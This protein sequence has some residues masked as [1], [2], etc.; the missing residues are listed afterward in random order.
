MFFDD[1]QEAVIPP[2]IINYFMKLH[3]LLGMPENEF[4]ENIYEEFSKVKI[5]ERVFSHDE[6]ANIILASLGLEERKIKNSRKV[7]ETRLKKMLSL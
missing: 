7:A 3:E 1:E 5:H 6:C 4:K 2:G